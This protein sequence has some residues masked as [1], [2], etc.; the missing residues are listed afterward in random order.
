MTVAVLG[1][2]G[3]TGWPLTCELL[4]GGATVVGV[5]NGSRRRR[6]APSVT[7]I[8]SADT[9]HDRANEVYDGTYYHYAF[10]IRDASKL[11]SVLR[12]H[13]PSTVVNLAQV[14]SAP[15]S[16]E[17]AE[18]AW[19]TQA[20]NVRGSLS[21][22]WT[23]YRLD[24]TD[25]HIVQLA[26]MGEY[27]AG[28]DIPEGFV[29]GMDDCPAP[30]L[31]GSFYHAS[32]CHMTT[33]TIFAS[34]LW[35]IPVSEIYQGIV[36]GLTAGSPHS[37]ALVTR[38]DMDA[39]WGT[40]IN[41]FTA[42]AALGMDLTV[43]GRGGQKRAMLPLSDC[44]ACLQL[45]IE[46]PPSPGAPGKYPYRA[47]NQFQGAYRVREV[48]ELVADITGAGI[49]HI[50]NP[51]TEDDSDHDYDPERNVLDN[52]GYE[53]TR[54]LATEIEDTYELVCEHTDRIHRDELLPETTWG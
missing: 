22:L 2:M 20:N 11:E 19:E 33:N 36:Y 47:I 37:D 34:R 53:P 32:K 10:D 45:A 5:D 7:A 24:M 6:A 4:A 8:A 1:D 31:P 48:A 3:Y 50:D 46:T 17:S 42:Q 13:E 35:G 40:V 25:T 49:Q 52:L 9:R 41:R 23:L 51:R 38:F 21:L 16:M 43:Y 27:P 14:P 28:N 12:D 39:T 44:L 18:N 30:K 29:D 54:S 26:T 15:F